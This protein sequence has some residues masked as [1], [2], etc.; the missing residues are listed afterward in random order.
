MRVDAGRRSLAHPS[1]QAPAA[2]AAGVSDRHTT[3]DPHAAFRPPDLR[4]E[5]MSD[6]HEVISA[7]LDDEPF[8]SNAL[9]EALSEPAGRELLID[10][11]ALRHLMR[12]EGKEAA[13]Q[14]VR[15]PWRASLPALVAAAAVLLALVG[16]YLAGERRGELAMSAAPP[17]TRVVQ[18]PAAWKDVRSGRMP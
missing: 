18:A 14:P 2:R 15:R 3:N 16:G 10:L 7:F 8:D 1:R 11:L 9:A 4:V 12:T 5:P 6:R 13:A 17:A